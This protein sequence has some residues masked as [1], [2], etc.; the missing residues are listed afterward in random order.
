[1]NL[2][3]KR[4]L[5]TKPNDLFDT[6]RL[7]RREIRAAGFSVSVIVKVNFLSSYVFGKYNNLRIISTPL[8]ILCE[9][10]NIRKG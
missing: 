9:E 10:D 7:S 6:V 4:Q 1:M 3:K 2:I 5:T 8:S